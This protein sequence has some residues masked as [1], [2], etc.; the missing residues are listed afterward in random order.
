MMT[1]RWAGRSLIDD[2]LQELGQAF[3]SLAALP[4]PSPAGIY[5]A[6][7][8]GPGWLRRLAPPA[9]A[10]GGLRGWWGKAFDGQ[11]AVNIVERDGIQL[12]VLPMAVLVAPSLVDAK[13]AI[14]LHYPKGSPFPWPWIVDEAR[15]LDETTLL[16]MTLVNLPWA[17]KVAFPFLL[18]R[19]D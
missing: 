3:R 15:R 11:G 10:L 5:R 2:S 18:H 6:E 14:S 8:V 13:P 7:L 12:R 17:P 4:L 19:V 16:C 1:A 9:L